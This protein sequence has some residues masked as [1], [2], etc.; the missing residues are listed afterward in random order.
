MTGT[1][2]EVEP[3]SATRRPLPSW[4]APLVAVGAVIAGLLPWLITGLRLPLQNLWAMATEPEDMPLVLLPFSQYSL[5]LIFAVLVVGSA[6]AGI[7]ARVL[8][9]R[10]GRRG[11]ALLLC[12]VPLLQAIAIVQAALVVHSGLQER[13]ES[14]FYLA[15]LVG[16][17]VLSLLI[18]VL[19]QVLIAMAPRAGALIGLSLGA[20]AA[21][22]WIGGFFQ[23]FMLSG[24]DWLLPVVGL[25]Q[26][27]TPVLTG[28]AIAWA[29]INTAGRAVAAILSVAL[30]WVAPAAMTG[31]GSA[32]GSR[33]LA[34]DPG[35]MIEYAFQVFGM[36]AFMPE[37]ALRPIVATILVA[38]IGLALR[39]AAGSGRARNS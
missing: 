15:A 3:A 36:A 16:V 28:I 10:L 32:A 24:P 26:W 23:P 7:A 30:A 8:R 31:I 1:S 17:S 25:I 21:S 13:T 38:A 34:R 19:A 4:A 29:G 12:T 22:S 5:A 20:V 27:V 9:S 6:A 35:A 33:V 14:V 39:R 37:L 11:F 2:T 18:G